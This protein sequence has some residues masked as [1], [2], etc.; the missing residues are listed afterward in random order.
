MSANAS[1]PVVN[2]TKVP[3]PTKNA[4]IKS[5]ELQKRGEKLSPLSLLL[6]TCDCGWLYLADWKNVII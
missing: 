4:E 6:M 5:G 1:A 2:A 3:A